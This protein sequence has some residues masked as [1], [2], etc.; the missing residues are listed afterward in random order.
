MF[1]STPS[2]R[3][4]ESTSRLTLYKVEFESGIHALL[5]QHLEFVESG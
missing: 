1:A 4:A 2:I 3:L 5:G